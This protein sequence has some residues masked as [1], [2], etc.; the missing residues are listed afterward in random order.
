VYLLQHLTVDAVI[1]YYIDEREEEHM[2][3]LIENP[4]VLAENG[5]AVDAEKV[6]RRY[7][8]EETPPLNQALDGLV[9]RIEREN[10]VDHRVSLTS[11]SMLPNGKLSAGSAGLIPTK[12][13]LSDLLGFME[14]PKN[15]LACLLSL[16]PEARSVAMVD[17]LH[18][19]RSD[20]FKKTVVARTSVAQNGARFIRAF[21]STSHSAEYG[22]DLAAVTALRNVFEGRMSEVKARVARTL[23]RTDIEVLV[24]S[25]S[26]FV[27]KGDA[28]I[29]RVHITNSEVR[30]SGFE[31]HGG[32]L[33]LVCTNGMTREAEGTTHRIVHRGD[34]RWR[35]KAAIE[36]SYTVVAPL[37]ESLTLAGREPLALPRGDIISKLEHATKANKVAVPASVWEALLHVW[38]LDGELSAGDTV[39]GLANALTRAAQQ[40]SYD[41]ASRIEAFAGDL[42]TLGSESYHLIAA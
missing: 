14:V 12:K 19:Q 8:L 25:A 42:V 28:V 16:R 39:A 17:W 2:T 36:G 30:S 38:D 27:K 13:A 15:A 40:Y 11:M 24:P 37:I 10:P 3:R 20:D 6:L 4:E 33:R 35:M 5:L 41:E 18:Q 23:D 7:R 21:V 31:A 22:D 1:S 34:L 26:G 9:A 29:A 32:L